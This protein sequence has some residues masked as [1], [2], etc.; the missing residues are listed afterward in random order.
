MALMVLFG[1]YGLAN[2]NTQFFPDIETKNI[3][4]SINWSGASAEDVE[5]NIL[6]VVEPEVRFIDGVDE[7]VSYAR[8]GSG[9][10][11]LDFTE[12]TDMIEARADVE[13][14]LAGITLLPD[15]SETPV[16]TTS[17]FADRVGRIAISGPFAEDALKSFARDLRDRLIAAASTWSAFPACATPNMP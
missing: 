8:E 1:I 4:I 5:S 6:T 12:T 9:S 13:Q 15:G 7:I 11:R 2:L 14:A 10:V 16:I 17:N 3:T